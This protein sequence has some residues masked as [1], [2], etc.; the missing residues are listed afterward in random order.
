M[1]IVHLYQQ[2]G[3]FL[4]AKNRAKWAFLACWKRNVLG[5]VITKHVLRL[6][7]NYY[8]KAETTVE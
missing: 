6:G 7:N 4:G 3:T 8:F 1:Y 2:A 5:F